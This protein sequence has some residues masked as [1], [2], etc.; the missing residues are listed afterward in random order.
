MKCHYSSQSGLCIF[1]FDWPHSVDKFRSKNIS[2]SL[3][4]DKHKQANQQ[5][6]QCRLWLYG[7]MLLDLT[8]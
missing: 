4:L 7:T 1:K 2:W 3:K 8:K 6:V 5:I